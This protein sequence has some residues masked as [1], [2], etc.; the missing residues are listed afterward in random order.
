MRG[1][2]VSLTILYIAAIIS[3]SWGIAHIIPT[4]NIVGG[5][6]DL[7][8][9]NRRVLVMEW[10]AEGLTLIFIGLLI[11]AV[12]LWGDEAET[13]RLVLRLSAAMLFAMAAL[14][15]VTGARTAILPMRLCPVV[16]SI[17]AILVLLGTL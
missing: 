10:I 8:S 12:S 2:T 13:S 1:L 4:Q 15:T 9:D 11:A 17:T 14:S 7:S 3:G 6:G 5:F 16:K